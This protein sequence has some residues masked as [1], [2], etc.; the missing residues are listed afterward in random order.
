[1][2]N[3]DAQLTL[4][5]QIANQV[6]NVANKRLEDGAPSLEIAAGLRQAAANFS[7]FALSQSKI[8]PDGPQN[9]VEDFIRSFEF[10]LDRHAPEAEPQDSLFQLIEEVKRES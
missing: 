1:M 6:V 7:A 5:I 8:G 4:S 9:L 3:E 10:Y 2:N